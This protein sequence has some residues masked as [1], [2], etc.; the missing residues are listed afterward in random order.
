LKGKAKRISVFARTNPED[1]LRLVRALQEQENVVAV[2]GDGVNDAPALAAADIGVAMGETGSDV[3]REAAAIVLADDD[4]AT[5]VM[6]IEQGRLIFA[7]LRK[8]VRYYLACKI[9]L[10]GATLLPVLLHVP[11]PFAPIQIILMEL[12]MD[13]AAAAAFVVERPES[14]LMQRPP[15]DRNQPFMNRE[16]VMSI[17]RSAAGLFAAVTFV[18]LFTWYGGRNL[19]LAQ[20]VAFVTWLIGHVFLAFNLRSEREPLARIGVFGNRVMTIWAVAAVAF[21]FASTA[22]GIHIAVKTVPLPAHTWALSVVSA[23]A[24]TF[25]IEVWKRLRSRRLLN[26]T[27]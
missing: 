4:F 18:Y 19:A 5:I 23:A 9:A 16:M 17:G 6:A 20:S 22:T 26:E 7:N 12:F 27:R 25:W 8:G 11:V 15:R 24:G 10:V 1:K 13:L 3:A 14:D 21:S 2:T